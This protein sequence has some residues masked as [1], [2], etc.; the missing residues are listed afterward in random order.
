MSPRSFQAATRFPAC[1]AQASPY[2]VAWLSSLAA[3]PA[4]V[5]TE[6]SVLESPCISKDGHNV[7]C[8]TVVFVLENDQFL[9]GLQVDRSIW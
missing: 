1:F 3:S 6:D 2:S 4:D 5:W 8:T 7:Y 9:V